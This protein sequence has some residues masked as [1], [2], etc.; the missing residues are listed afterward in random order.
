[1]LNNNSS[2]RQQHADNLVR[3][4]AQYTDQRDIVMY[5]YGKHLDDEFPAPPER[6]P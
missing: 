5:L 6:F 1:M 2:M 4:L 3:L